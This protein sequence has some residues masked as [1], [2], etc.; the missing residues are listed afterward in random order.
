[1]AI[2][3]KITLQQAIATPESDMFTVSPHGALH[4][5]RDAEWLSNRIEI[6]IVSRGE[7][8]SRKSGLSLLAGTLWQGLERI[9]S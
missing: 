1:M 2:Q 9:S 3:H 8:P 4:H 7:R 6:P 5:V